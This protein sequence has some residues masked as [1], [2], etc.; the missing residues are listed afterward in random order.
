MTSAPHNA[1]VRYAVH[2]RVTMTM[3]VLGV[4]VLGWLSLGR[5]PLEYLPAF[6]SSNITV[7]APYPS[8]SPEEVERLVV[9][10]LED[11]LGTIN[12]IE[13]LSASATANSA[14]ISVGFLDGTDMD[15]AGVEVRDRIERA[16]HLLPDD[17]ERLTIRRFQ[18][19]DIP[20]LRFDLSAA[21]PAERLYE[22]T[23][24]VVQRRLER[25]EGVAQVE[26]SGLRTPQ[27]QINLDPDRLQAHGIDV[28]SLVTLLRRSNV[29]LSGGDIREGSRKL[30]VRTVGEFAHPREIRELP[31]NA[32]GL[33]LGDVAEVAYDFPEQQTFNFLNGI[34]AL[35]VRINKASASN[36]L[37]VV[38]RVKAEMAKIEQLPEAEGI[39]VRIYSDASRDVRQGLG[40]LRDAGLVGGA[41]AIVAM[42]FFLRR[43]R[44]TFL[45]AVAIPLSVVST[46]VLVYFMRQAGL[47]DITLN[48]VSLAGLMLALGMLV[49]NSVVVIES[50]F[51]HRNELEEDA[52]TA[53]LAGTSEVALPIIAS[54]ATTMCVFLPL[55]FLGAGGRFKLYLENIGL[56]ICIVIVAS[57]VVALTVV[58]MAAAVVLRGQ[59]PRPA[60]FIEGITRTYGRLLGLT[61]HHRF[62]F[63]VVIAGLLAGSLWLFTTIERAFSTHALERQVVIRVDTPR[64]YSLA[65]TRALYEEIYG[66][67]DARRDELA[68]ADISYAYDRT[69]GRSRA[70]WRRARQFSVYLKDEADSHLTTAEVRDRIRELLPVKAGIS[71][72]LAQSRGRHGTS[73]VEVELMGDDPVVLE[74]ISQ[75]VAAR[76]A[77]LPMIRDVDTTLESGDQ[78]IHIT[79][80]RERATSSGLSSRAV[81]FTVANA[82]SSRAISH[83]K[84]GDREVDLVMQLQE[85]DRETLDQLKNLQVFTGEGHLPLAALADFEVAPGPR[86]IERENHRAKVT[87]SANAA[88]SAMSF[89]AMGTI[90]RLMD[91][92]SLP[93]GYEWSFGRWNR[94]QQRD[95][96]MGVYMWLFALPLVYMLLAALFES[97]TQPFTIMFS[98]PFALLGVGVVMKLANQPWETMTI[99]GMI[100]LMGIV[101]NNAIVLINHINFLRQRGLGRTEA[102]ILGGQHR[103]RP[104]L[105]TAIT[106]ILG[107]A[108]LVAPFLLPQWFGQVEGRA[109]TW[110]PIGLVI[111]GGL[112]T[113]TFLTLMIIPTIYSLVDDVT[114]FVRRVAGAAIGVLAFTVLVGCGDDPSRAGQAGGEA[115]QQG[116]DRQRGQRHGPPPEPAAAAVPVEVAPV[117][118]RAISSYIETNGTLEAENEVD[119]VA[120]T[121]GPVVELR[122]EEGDA[123]RR[124]DL[125]ARLDEAELLAQLE[126]ARVNLNEARLAYERAEQLESDALISSESYDQAASARE[127][128]RAQFDGNRIQLGY[129][130]IKA[131]FAGLI[132]RRYV[133]LAEHVATGQ[134]LFRISDFT[135]LLCPIQVPERELRR[136]RVGQ[137]AHI[138][139]EAFPGERFEASVLRLSPV[140]DA[141]TGT[142]KVTLEV[143]ARDLLRPGM[144]ARVFLQTDSRPD[145][146]VIPKA[147]LSLESIGDTVYVAAQDTASR[148]EVELGFSEGNFVEILSGVAE[149]DRVVVVGQDGLS[150]GTP[151]RVLSGAGGT[152]RTGEGPPAGGRFDLTAATPE[153]LERIKQLMRARGLTDE[154]IEER[155][156]RA[157]NRA[158]ASAP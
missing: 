72:R 64:Q 38:N 39:A 94:F 95:Q 107:M 157:R 19:S 128:A 111:V 101:V 106:T 132:V 144:F 105:I 14:R 136:L 62:A 112:T 8:S 10:P 108:P 104:I 124:G 9:R 135:P 86:S 113:S 134:P 66:L 90:G 61:L 80:Q 140:V 87:V 67:L 84:T 49:D 60:R 88:S 71:L 48:V 137:S 17:L 149:H 44:T 151:I 82:L 109:A 7:I 6:S 50:I 52:T 139:V 13:T 103:L 26:I 99:I 69:T 130:Q 96:E 2:H 155:L 54:T 78:E 141:A 47:V 31:L 114:S 153:Q 20:V 57:L 127:T 36:L 33:R 126:I 55:I 150:D 131:P 154:Q 40:Q 4:L 98:V 76:L 29:N 146:L 147:A 133:D 59:S 5:L 16:R 81:A 145:A 115:G 68:I 43:V 15:M 91:E 74:L 152:E 18:S 129:A 34:E 56:T 148:R 22:F 117:V 65:Q 100:V 73:G 27:L 102:I 122:A 116:Q 32:D 158:G 3:A 121:P 156:R 23:E 92:I 83:F 97:F 70:S 41:L 79:V 142:I 24:T 93:P 1:L 21:W 12:G 125:L 63:V 89:M 35:T 118:R 28:R 77:Q 53:A 30:L 25:L 120:R 46:F 11:A 75:Q 85:K 143:E 42:F 123:V 37:D 51:R 119:L 110:A 138:T 58:P 45:V